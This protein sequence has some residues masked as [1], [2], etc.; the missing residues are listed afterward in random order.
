MLQQ[1]LMELTPVPQSQLLIDTCLIGEKRY[2][3]WESCVLSYDLQL[4]DPQTGSSRK[5][6]VSARL[7]KPAEGLRELG[8]A[9]RR[10]LF[11]TPGL[12][13]LAHLPAT[14]M[15]VWVF[16]NDRKLTH[17]P[18][19]LNHEFLASYLPAML[20]SAGLD[21]FAVLDTITAEVLHYLPE[22]SCMIRYRLTAK[23]RS[24]EASSTV[25]LYGK[26]Y[27]DDQGEDT[28]SVMRQCAAQI[29]GDAVPL[30]YDQELK[31]LWQSHVPGQSVTWDM[32]HSKKAPAVFHAIAQCLGTFHR[33]NIRT[34][35]RFGLPDIDGSLKE[36]T[37]MA[38]RAYPDMADR[39]QSLVDTLLSQRRSLQWSEQPTTPLHRDLKMSNFLIDGETARLIDLDCVSIGDPLTDLASLITNIH[40]N[41]LYA[42]CHPETINTIVGALRAAY[43]DLVPYPVSVPHLN[44]YIA[45]AFIHEVTRRSMRQLDATRL[46]HLHDYLDLSE[47]Y[48]SL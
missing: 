8:E 42:G 19:L 38:R 1:T 7:C 23:D 41:G 22:R 39:I 30:V 34:P 9:N 3:P 25:T 27:R 40:I 31:T 21:N 4:R 26:I 6:V 18:Q 33:C 24:T 20:A 5:Q 10:E 35:S 36:A 37:E 44:W 11:S 28:Y 43:R 48:A 45:A 46:R 17:L 14:D 47:Q 13:P 15:V 32:L 12:V 2:K 29:P 16:P